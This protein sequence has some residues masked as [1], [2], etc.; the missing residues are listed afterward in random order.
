MKYL[1]LI[2]ILLLGLSACDDVSDSVVDTRSVQTNLLEIRSPSKVT[3][4]LSDVR[5]VVSA[6]YDNN[7]MIESVWM[8]IKSND[9]RVTILENE[10]MTDDGNSSNGDDVAN[11][12][13]YSKAFNLTTAEPSEIYS[14]VIYTRLND[15]QVLKS[16]F[17]TLEY[18]NGLGNVAPV[19][20]NLV[21]PESIKVGELFTFT[22]DAFDENGLVD[23]TDVY[24]E[25]YRPDGSFRG[26][27]SMHDD[28]DDIF[29][30]SQA[31]DGTYSFRNRFSDTESDSVQVG[32]YRFDFQAIDRRNVK[33]EVISQSIVVSR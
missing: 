20:S 4:L 16:G 23:I 27:V 17:R 9:S 15:G 24:F 1:V 31:F 26:K 33:S 22:V 2:M 32:A 14:I 10:E 8:D 12:A 30:D 11:D 5:V 13:R 29:G 7:E 28:G 25:F 6:K 21:M 3:R 19:L 18:D